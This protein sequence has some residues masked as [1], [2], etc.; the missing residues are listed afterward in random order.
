MISMRLPR[1]G[2]MSEIATRKGEHK[3]RFELSSFF[4]AFR[5]ISWVPTI[6]NSW[7]CFV[8]SDPELLKGPGPTMARILARAQPK[9]QS[10]L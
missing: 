5:F 9:A 2:T 1:S 8:S 3:L 6:I 10:R 4:L 7:P